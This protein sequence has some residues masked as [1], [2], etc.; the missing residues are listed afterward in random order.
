MKTISRLLILGCAQV[1]S[2]NYY[3]GYQDQGNGGYYN[4]G[5]QDGQGYQGQ[6]YYQGGSQGYYQKIEQASPY[7]Q[8]QQNPNDW[9]RS[10][11]KQ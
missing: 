3:Q 10:D 4:S 5:Y 1:L 7:Q 2:A 11:Q 6:A 9:S 8:V